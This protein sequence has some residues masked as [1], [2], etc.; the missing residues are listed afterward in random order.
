MTPDRLPGIVDQPAARP[1]LRL[2]VCPDQ[3]GVWFAEDDRQIAWQQTL[4]EMAFA[5]FRYLEIGPYG[6]LPTDPTRLSEQLERRGMTAVAGTVWARLHDADAWPRT[7]ES[8][9][10]VAG[11]L[12]AVGAEV[13]VYLPT[14]YRDDKTGAPTEPRSLDG[15]AWR[16]YLRGLNRLGP[17]V[18]RDYGLRLVL[19]PHADTHIATTADLER[20]L[21]ETDPGDLGLCLDTGHVAYAGGDPLALI[22]SYP[23]R[24]D[25]VHLKAMDPAVV[26][27]AHAEDWP[28]GEAVARGCSVAPPAGTPQLGPVLE[29]L[30]ALDRD[31]YVICEQDLY[32]CDPALPLPN[33]IAIRD[34]LAGLGLRP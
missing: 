4:D 18:R 25:Y 8:V 7:E 23:D 15:P 30:S 9:R 22:D 13:L 6:Y 14:L 29:A 28:F 21:A 12:A 27:Q 16:E 24:I 33:A 3:W 19:H 20:V 31:L 26:A 10:A 11:L 2:G 1:R 32:P 5:G 34:H 17:L